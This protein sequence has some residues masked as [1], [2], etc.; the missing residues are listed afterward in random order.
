MNKSFETIK[1][2]SNLNLRQ[3]RDD[4]LEK[5][6]IYQDEREDLKRR[7][8]LSKANNKPF[9]ETE[10]YLSDAANSVLQNKEERDE[11]RIWQIIT[12]FLA[13]LAVVIGI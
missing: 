12:A 1:K 7:G 11:I 9:P 13:F 10:Y 4:H 6:G 5:I 8:F 2:I 3:I